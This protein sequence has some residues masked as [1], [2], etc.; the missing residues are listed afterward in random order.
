MWVK[1]RK[2]IGIYG[3]SMVGKSVFAAILAKEFVGDEG[4]VIIYGTEEHYSDDDYRGMISGFLPKNNYINYCGSITDLFR[5]MNILLHKRIEG[6]L[7]L[8]LDS[9]SFIAMRETGYLNAR[10]IIEPRAVSA[11]VVPLLYSVSSLFKKLVVEKDAL[12]IMIMHASSMAGTG[13]FRGIVDLKPSMA[14][15]V[16]HSLDYLLLMTSEG[17]R[18]EDPRTITVVA[19]R[20]NPA[21]EGQS[22]KFVFKDTTVVKHVGEEERSSKQKTIKQFSK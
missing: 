7:A 16:A 14:M 6:K 21:I 22:I 10:G 3:S 20:L 13:K 8:I 2:N 4:T 5:Y 19:S 15:R 12:G 18:L 1:S 11:R 17:A 9:L